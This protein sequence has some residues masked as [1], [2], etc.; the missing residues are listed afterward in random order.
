MEGERNATRIVRRQVGIPAK[1]GRFGWQDPRIRRRFHHGCGERVQ[2]H[3]DRGIQ[4]HVGERHELVR[5]YAHD[6]ASSRVAHAPCAW[7]RGLC[8]GQHAVQSGG[9]GQWRG[10]VPFGNNNDYHEAW[11]T[12]EGGAAELTDLDLL[13]MTPASEEGKAAITPLFALCSG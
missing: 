12:E 8:A 7:H 2:V 9:P 10:R 4:R 13:I 3:P 5:P 11:I 1:R 6:H